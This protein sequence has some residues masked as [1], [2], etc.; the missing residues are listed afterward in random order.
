MLATHEIGKPLSID[1][2]TLVVPTDPIFMSF[3]CRAPVQ[4]PSFITLFIH[5]QGFQVKVE[6]TVL[7]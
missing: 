7:D 6:P 1:D 5:L 4:L 2:T 3:G